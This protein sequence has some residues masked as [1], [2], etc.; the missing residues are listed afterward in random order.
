MSRFFRGS[1]GDFLINLVV[2]ILCGLSASV[3]NS[4]HNLQ[5]NSIFENLKTNDSKFLVYTSYIV[6][7]IL[8]LYHHEMWR[9]EYEEYLQARDAEGLFGLGNTMSQGH[10]MLWQ[11][12]LWVI[13]R[14]THNPVAMK[15]FH[16][17]IAASFA[18]VLIF[19][20]PFKLWQSGLLLLS[21]FLLFEYA[22]ISRCYAFGVL[23]FM[24]FALNYTKNQ[25]LTWKTGI[26]LFLLANTSIYAMM[27]TTVLVGWLFFMEV[28]LGKEDWKVK[29]SERLPVLVLA[30]CGILLAYLQIRPQPDNTFPIHRVLL[31]FNVY[32]YDVALSQFFSAFVPIVKIQ[33]QHFWNTNILSNADGI[34]MRVFPILALILTT[35]P[36][37]NKNSILVLWLGGIIAVLFFQYHTGFY[38]ARYYG[39]FFLWWLVCM[40]LLTAIDKPDKLNRNIRLAVFCLVLVS[41]S[42]GGI[43]IYAADWNKKFSRGAEAA[44]FLKTNGYAKKYMIGSVDFA[45]SP[46]AAELDK[47]IYTMQHKKLGSYTKWDKERLNSMD[48]ADIVEAL[49]SGPPN[50]TMIFIA[51]HPIPQFE[52][53]KAMEEKRP[54]KREFVFANYTFN[55]LAYFKPGVEYYEGYWLFKV[56]R[57]G[58]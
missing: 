21:Y 51:T 54:L 50:E 36:F 5:K 26:I 28:I 55:C 57:I 3:R 12:C 43:L 10:A 18:F 24:V 1:H 31:P 37:I 16:G 7:L 19:K 49:E 41:Q 44:H 42:I 30:G 56:D 38:F 15:I 35:L 14:F 40:W 9:D 11:G 23:L 52:Y 17:L 8:G 33:N 29:L 39:H 13:T 48:S 32:R 2:L 47:K 27:L 4:K 46:I 58:K 25:R 6:L 20:S 22:V 45:L 53:F 34:S